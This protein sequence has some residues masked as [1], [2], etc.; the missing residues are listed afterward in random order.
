M[1][2]IL[3]SKHPA[4]SGWI[5]NPIQKLH[6]RLHKRR[7]GLGATE[8]VNDKG[9]PKELKHM[10]AKQIMAIALALCA[11]A[12]SF[13]L[14]GA[15][16][17]DAVS[18]GQT[19][20]YIYDGSQWSDHPGMPGYNAL[21]ALQAT[22]E[23]IVADTDYILEKENEWGPYTEMNSNYGNVTS[24]DGVAEN[25][26]NVWNVFVYNGGWSVGIDAI[27]FITPFSDGAAPSANVVF[28]YGA[29]TEAVPGDVTDHV[30]SL[31]ALTVPQETADYQYYFQLKVNAA[32]YS[33]TIADGT[34]VTLVDGT[35]K[36]LGESDLSAGII[37]VGYGSNAYSALKNAVG[38]ANI[39]ATETAGA[40]YGWID[41]LFGL[42]TVSAGSDYVYWT[43]N[44]LAGQY[45]SFNMGAYSTLDN[46]PSDAGSSTE[47][48]NQFAFS[49]EYVLYSYS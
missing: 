4:N 36:I 41:S 17:S 44:T 23:T 12:G 3:R 46:V 14:I 16:D 34:E 20:V 37:V 38:S 47:N 40:Y 25:A 10:N 18:A 33:P 5:Y 13:A 15:D 43:Q 35:T 22:G 29:D 11:V 49:L 9:G 30:T 21:Q 48:F 45:L 19:N 31:A 39:A 26:S 2:R 42:T 6:Y 27:G 1:F 8:C 24:I 28:Y 7:I 32:G